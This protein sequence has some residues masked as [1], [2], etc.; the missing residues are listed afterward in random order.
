MV[1]AM[2]LAGAKKGKGG[3]QGQWQQQCEGGGRQRGQGQQCD[4]DGEGDKDGEQVECDGNEEVDGNGEEGGGQA[5][6]TA[7]KRVMVTVTRVAG[8]KKAMAMAANGK[9]G[10]EQA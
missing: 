8:D 4:G 1:M 2:R 10:G 6:A 9:E 3:L 5:T 7:T